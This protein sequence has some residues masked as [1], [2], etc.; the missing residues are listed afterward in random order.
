MTGQPYQA[1]SLDRFVVALPVVLLPMMRCPTCQGDRPHFVDDLS[2]CCTAC[3][4]QVTA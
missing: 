1:D 3:G 2:H 4:T